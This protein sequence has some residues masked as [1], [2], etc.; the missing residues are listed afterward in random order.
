MEARDQ[1]GYW[2]ILEMYNGSGPGKTENGY[3][4]PILILLKKSK[5]LIERTQTKGVI[6]NN[7]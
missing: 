7:G 4:E 3:T 5:E 6:C 2:K 1:E